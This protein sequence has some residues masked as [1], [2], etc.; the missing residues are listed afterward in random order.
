MGGSAV[1]DDK[2]DVRMIQNPVQ[3]SRNHVTDTLVTGTMDIALGHYVPESDVV[4]E[5]HGFF[6][7]CGH[8]N[9]FLKKTRHQFPETVLGMTIVKIFLPAFDRSEEH[10][11]ELQSQR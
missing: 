8:R 9:R 3:I 11:S 1:G 2:P 5:K 10:T 4:G 6:L 7:F